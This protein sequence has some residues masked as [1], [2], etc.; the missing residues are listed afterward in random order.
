MDLYLQM[1]PPFK[2]KRKLNFC[3]FSSIQLEKK[4]KNN[5]IEPS[6]TKKI[7]PI[8][9][10]LILNEVGNLHPEVQ[11]YV[12]RVCERLGPN[13]KT[14]IGSAYDAFDS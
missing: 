5:E 4:Q 12:F 3:D 2:S 13:G 1:N 11:S 8:P 6:N 10:G 14:Y 9:V 7:K